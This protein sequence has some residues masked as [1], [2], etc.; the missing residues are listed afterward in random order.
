MQKLKL[1]FHKA[2]LWS[3]IFNNRFIANLLLSVIVQEL[4]KWLNIW[5]SYDNNLVYYFLHHSVSHTRC[6]KS[7]VDIF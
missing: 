2:V 4:W 3:E 7:Y 1:I 6:N 5:P